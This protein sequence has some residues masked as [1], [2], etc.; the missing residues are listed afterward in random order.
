MLVGRKKQSGG[1]RRHHHV[2]LRI[3]IGLIVV[4]AI[5]SA[6]AIYFEQETRMARM[7]QR[8]SELQQALYEAQAQ[9]A[10]LLELQ[11]LIGTEAYIER[12][13]RD[14]LG[15]VKPNEIVFEE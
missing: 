12:I 2:L 10:E 5:A 9:H 15:M 3:T 14:K 8:Q 6:V 1:R 11:S 7:Q 13:A 4:F